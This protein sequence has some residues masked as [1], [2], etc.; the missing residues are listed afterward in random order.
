MVGSAED[1]VVVV[2]EEVEGGGGDVVGG[3][4]EDGVVAEGG[5]EREGFRGG[6]GEGEDSCEVCGRDRDTRC[7]S[8]SE[9]SE[10]KDRDRGMRIQR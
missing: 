7:P 1:T 9:V 2:V 8:I 6:H 10:H 5:E 3:G 4:E